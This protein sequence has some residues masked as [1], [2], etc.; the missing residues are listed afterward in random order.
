MLKP[1]LYH[2]RLAHSL[3]LT[4]MLTLTLTLTLA[5]TLAFTC[6]CKLAAAVAAVALEVIL[7][8]WWLQVLPPGTDIPAAFA[9]GSD[10]E[11]AFVQNLALF[12][13]SFFKVCALPPPDS[14]PIRLRLDPH[15]CFT[16]V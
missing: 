11:Q 12:L 15:I 4:L 8:T 10:E 14:R 2:F 6:Q 5:L 13:T 7:V 16:M 9:S 3:S 1:R